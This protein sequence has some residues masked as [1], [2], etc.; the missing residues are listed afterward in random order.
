MKKKGRNWGPNP[1]KG[2]AHLR[3]AGEKDNLDLKR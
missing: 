3:E 1:R 2:N